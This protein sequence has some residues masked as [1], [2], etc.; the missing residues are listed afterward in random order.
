MFTIIHGDKIEDSLVF[1]ER[2]LN[3]YTNWQ[4][5]RY[6]LKIENVD[7]E[8]LLYTGN[9]FAQNRLLIIKNFFKSK[10]KIDFKSLNFDQ[11]TDII[12][13]ES[14]QL[15]PSQLTKFP[16]NS[17]IYLF[18]SDPLIFHF[19]DELYPGNQKYLFKLYAKIQ[20]Q[21][22]PQ[23]F[24]AMFIRHIKYLLISKNSSSDINIPM[25]DWQIKKYKTQ[26]AKLSQEKLI[27][28]YKTLL[29]IDLKVKTGEITNHFA[30]LAIILLQL[31]KT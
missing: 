19:F 20:V 18:K 25:P 31:T 15:T 24:F 12:I 28:T 16:K 27:S 8:S 10:N 5:S 7:L 6:D 29:K 1:L 13:F 9:L 3:D 21:I 23:F 22:E 11:N 26:A 2:L 17:K 30:P 4:I 14:F